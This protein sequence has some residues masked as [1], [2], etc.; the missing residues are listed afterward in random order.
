M[1]RKKWLT[2]HGPEGRHMAKVIKS[3]KPKSSDRVSL[4][5]ENLKAR[6]QT[7]HK[8]SCDMFDLKS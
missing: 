5:K 8:T 7:I 1:P 4:E 6:N 2:E 3:I